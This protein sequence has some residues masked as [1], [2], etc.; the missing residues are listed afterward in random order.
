MLLNFK[1][2]AQ[3]NL[4]NGLQD[5]FE[6][7]ARDFL[8]NLGYEVIQEPDRG[9]DGKKDL[10]IKEVRKG[11]AGLTEKLWVV[12]CKH[13]IFSGKSVSQ[14]DEPDILD[15]VNAH[16][17]D[18]FI[19][20]YSTLPSASLTNKLLGLK[21]QIE[22]QTYD[23]EKIEKRLL[24]T[25]DGNKLAERYFPVSYK[26]FKLEN[27]T[28]VELWNKTNSLHCDNC[29]KDLLEDKSGI[30]VFLVDKNRNY[31]IPTH[32]RDVYF[33]C[34]G[35]CDSVLRYQ[36]IAKGLYDSGW[37]DIPDITI[38]NVFFFKMNTIINTLMLG[39]T[40]EQKAMTKI[41]KMF[42]ACLPYICRELTT[43]EK[44]KIK[45]LSQIPNWLGGMGI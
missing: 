17:C 22:S 34:K 43:D 5:T 28:P 35:K 9:A 45:S 15:R 40:Y 18:G 33:S 37:D 6:L 4:G 32:T 38:P 10:V 23:R 14:D 16:K 21:T 39:E 26:S 7:F 1:E 30:F 12:S 11:I 27:P 41:Q 44:E 24:E 29:G 8:E 13:F 19:G 2:I 31:N 36:H 25:V 42:T 3:A 20:F